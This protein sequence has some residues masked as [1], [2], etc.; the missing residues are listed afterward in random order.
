MP[1]MAPEESPPPPPPPPLFELEL[2]DVDVLSE[3]LMAVALA[4]VPL[5]EA[6]VMAAV[7]P[8]GSVVGPEA[9]VLPI[10]VT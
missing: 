4:P 7:K 9:R 1:S 2:K 5:A 8:K 10:A 6:W 3:D